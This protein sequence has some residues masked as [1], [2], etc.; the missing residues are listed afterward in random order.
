MRR[1]RK[2]GKVLPIRLATNRGFKL[3]SSAKSMEKF[4]AEMELVEESFTLG[5]RCTVD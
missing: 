4:W 1:V 2:L 5:F 3:Q